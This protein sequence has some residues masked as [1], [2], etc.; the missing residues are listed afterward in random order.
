VRPVPHAPLLPI[1]GGAAAAAS[2]QSYEEDVTT[3][4]VVAAVVED[5][6]RYLVTRRQAGVHL[7]GL[8]EFPGGKV[9]EHESHDQALRRE[10]LEELGVD[11][12]VGPLVLSTSHAYPDRVVTLYF[13]RCRLLGPAAPLLGQQMQWVTRAQLASMEF[14]PADADLIAVLSA[15]AHTDGTV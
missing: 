14:P 15:H 6:Q 1:V 12:E 4:N 9:G 13:Y 2:P 8:W 11:V 3:V 10:M 5:G 7:A